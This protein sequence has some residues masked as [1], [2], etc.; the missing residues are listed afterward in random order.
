MF[1]RELEKKV[2]QLVEAEIVVNGGIV[3]RQWKVIH[4]GEM[5]VAKIVQR[6]HTDAEGNVK[7]VEAIEITRP[8]Q[9]VSCI[10]VPNVGHEPKVAV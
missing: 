1:R 4:D 5:Y 8:V 2:K 9:Y 10:D 7:H 6:K 3:N